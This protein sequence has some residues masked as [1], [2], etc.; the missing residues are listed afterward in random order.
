[1]TVTHQQAK[2][3]DT[4]PFAISLRGVEK[5]FGAVRANHN[6]DLDIC[7]GD[8]HGII[9]ENGAGKSTLVS[10]LY[11]F[12]QADAGTIS[13]F[14]E[15]K[16]LVFIQALDNKEYKIDYSKVGTPSFIKV[17]QENYI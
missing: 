11:G 16:T 2:G 13:V 14:G 10:I 9:G 3:R 12:Y 1:M 8:I 4:V 17:H 15:E 7:T 5:T 6:I